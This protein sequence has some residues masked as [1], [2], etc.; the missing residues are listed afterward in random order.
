M[1]SASSLSNELLG[2]HDS[3][4]DVNFHVFLEQDPMGSMRQRCREFPTDAEHLGYVQR[5]S[6]SL[7][8]R[9]PQPSLKLAEP[10]ASTR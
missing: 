7:N 10:F 3:H 8:R 2:W 1:C 5:I 4:D 6:A 9:L